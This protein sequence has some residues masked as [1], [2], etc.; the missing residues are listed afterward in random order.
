VFVNTRSG[1]SGKYRK[2]NMACGKFRSSGVLLLPSVQLRLA[3]TKA[4]SY[5]FEMADTQR[6]QRIRN[7]I[8]RF[9]ILIM[10]RANAG[11]TTILQRV[12]KTRE[13]PE[14]IDRNG[15]KVG[16]RLYADHDEQY[17][18]LCR[19]AFRSL[20]AHEKYISLKLISLNA[21]Y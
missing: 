13:A 2:P 18:Y 20:K 15:N 11:K 3:T 17:L 8:P 19:S 5:S 4:S 12:C 14:V 9:R 1:Q 7:R 21:Y 16:P 10:G 6:G